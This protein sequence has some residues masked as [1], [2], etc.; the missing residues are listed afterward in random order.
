[1]VRDPVF[2]N[3]YNKAVATIT[4][5]QLKQVLRDANEYVAR[6]HYVVSLL[7]P[8]EYSL[9]QPWLKGYH[10]QIYSIWMGVGGAQY[11]ELLYSAILD[12]PESEDVSRSLTFLHAAFGS[13]IC[14]VADRLKKS[15]CQKQNQN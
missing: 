5:D 14:N 2:D 8:M 11:V 3:F 1:M 15:S 4:E 6:Q 7:Q 10:A 12:R 13:Q 9:C